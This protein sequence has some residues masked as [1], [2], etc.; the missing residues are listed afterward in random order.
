MNK[1]S[2]A[3]LLE[4]LQECLQY[5]VHDHES[6][7]STVN[8]NNFVL[9]NSCINAEGRLEM[10]AL[11]NK[12]LLHRLPDNYNLAYSVLKSVHKKYKTQPEKL[13][14]YDAAIKQQLCDG[15]IEEV[16]RDVISND[17]EASYLAHNAVFRENAASTKCRV[18]FLSNLCDKK[19]STNLSHN[20]V[21]LPGCQL[22]NKIQT[23]ATLYRFNKYLLV[24]DL[25]KAFVQ[26]CLKENDLKKL[27]FLWYRDLANGDKTVVSYRFKRVPFGLRF[28]PYLL[29]IALYIILILCIVVADHEEFKIR[30]QLYNL[31]YMDNLG[32]SSSDPEEMV[33]AY[34]CSNTIFSE[35]QF[36]LQQF[37]TNCP[38]L[39]FIGQGDSVVK[40]F[41]LSWDRTNDTYSVNKPCLNPEANTKRKVLQ[42]LNS[43]FDPLG[44]VLPTLIRAKLFLHKLQSNMDVN[45]DAKLSNDLVKEW[46]TIAKQVNS[47]ANLCVPRYVGDYSDPYNL[48][49]FTDASKDSYGCVV[50]LQNCVTNKVEFC[51]AKNRLVP[52]SSNKTIPVLELLALGFGVEV[53]KN[54]K[55]ELTNA[56][57]PVNIIGV[58]VFTDS[59]IA[60][61]WL[62]SKSTKFLKIERKGLIVN[63]SLD[64]IMKLT[65]QC[66]MSFCHIEGSYNPA[67]FVT[68]GTSAK[69]LSK[70]N[71]FHSPLDRLNADPVCVIPEAIGITVE[72]FVTEQALFAPVNCVVPVTRYSSFRKLCRVVHYVR[73]F[74]SKIKLR[75]KQ[76]NDPGADENLLYT[77]TVKY[78]IR[79][80]QYV[81]YGPV[82]EYF[83]NPSLKPPPVVTQLNL[84]VVDG[85]IRVKGKCAKLNNF[86]E[87]FPI[88]LHKKCDF[89]AMLIL[90]YHHVLSHAG[91]Y[92][93]L[94]VLRREFWIPAAYMTCKRLINKCVICK[95]LHGRPVLINQNDYKDYRINPS[96]VPFRDIALDHIGPFYIRN[97]KD[98]KT[99]IYLL[100]ITCLFTRAI[101]LIIC[102]HLSNE[103]LLEALQIHI[104]EFGIPQF[105]LSDNG[106]SIVSSIKSMQ[107]FLKDTDVSNFLSE[108][109]IKPLVFAPYPSNASYLGGVVESLVKQV[110]H[111]MSTSL[112]RSVLSFDKFF[113]LMNECKMLVNK[114]PIA[115]KNSVTDNSTDFS[116]SPLTPEVLL[117]GYDVPSILVV[118]HIHGEDA[119]DNY[120]PTTPQT[121]AQ[122]FEAFN[123]LRRVRNKLNSVYASEFLD[124]LRYQSVNFPG[125]YTCKLHRSLAP[126]DLVCIKSKMA[127]PFDY[128][129][130]VV[131]E[132]E[133]NDLDE[134]VHVSVR[135]ANRVVVRRHVS[136]LVFLQSGAEYKEDNVVNS[137]PKNTRD[138]PKRRAATDCE[139]RI[140]KLRDSGSI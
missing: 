33:R 82:F 54:L 98:E 56:F 6:N 88:L 123:D 15:I 126:G 37:A 58:K 100:I 59:T 68:R 128:P 92:K 24:Y 7:N 129:C 22:N 21:S 106:S 69:L 79:C 76:R 2:D 10:P 19:N 86:R 34:T 67:D 90:D 113:V 12:A 40:L 52:Q 97:D 17:P 61:N 39:D 66:P 9:E 26:L 1:A 57:C 136:D 43:I 109:S 48:I 13:K 4:T 120:D 132:V 46:K 125:R 121:E 36:N 74:V 133:K 45:W 140:S 108:R 32:F 104:Y 127:K 31:S 118:P 115:L 64:K 30:K 101:N 103:C 130:A 51:L 95:R 53:V 73:K 44:M 49:V 23:T 134:V 99:K 25:E 55:S 107:E 137:V 89:T 135:K 11:W 131:L 77:D 72:S 71:Y 70:S 29:M 3:H 62:T 42:S 102:R 105:I 81:H 27:H 119:R 50:Y 47:S 94:A 84:T 5:D 124:S 20:Q 122:L 78:V 139:S 85:L 110:K 60:L 96:K 35:F 8:L 18:V 16:D 93:L 87:R 114:R 63:N 116:V 65:E 117:R 14:Q 80:A 28:S 138:V 111:I 38:E 75:L 83:Q 112:G 91:V 41:G